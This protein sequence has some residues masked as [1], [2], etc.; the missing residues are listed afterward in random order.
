MSVL[1]LAGVAD[2]GMIL[3]VAASASGRLTSEAM[4]PERRGRVDEARAA[5]RGRG[6]SSEACRDSFGV[7]GC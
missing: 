5:Q 4:A 7:R 3:A 1:S 6:R 2:D